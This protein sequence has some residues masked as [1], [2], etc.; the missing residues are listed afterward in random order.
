GG[1]RPEKVSDFLLELRFLYRSFQ[2]RLTRAGGYQHSQARLREQIH[3]EGRI[4]TESMQLALQPHGV[5]IIRAERLL[6]RRARATCGNELTESPRSIAG[7]LSL[8]GEQF[9][10]AALL[11][12]AQAPGLAQAAEA[13]DF[14][15]RGGIHS[16]D[17]IESGRERLLGA[18]QRD[19]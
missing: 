3:D 12:R 13:I 15:A 14:R 6:R 1:D 19:L 8:T 16:Q 5:D 4:G 11:D 2:H 7:S 9:I 10:Q 17:G 18:R